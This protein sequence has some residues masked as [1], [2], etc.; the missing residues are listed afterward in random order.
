MVCV[1]KEKRKREIGLGHLRAA[2]LRM[3]LFPTLA[4]YWRKQRSFFN[5]EK[6]RITNKGY[7]EVKGE[8]HV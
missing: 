5:N 4:I 1:L 6:K 3:L 8:C 2:Y 7:K